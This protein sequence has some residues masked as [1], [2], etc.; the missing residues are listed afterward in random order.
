MRSSV[1]FQIVLSIISLS[2]NFSIDAQVFGNRQDLGLIQ[3]NPITEAS[4]I[5]VSRKNSDV[6][7]TH[8]DSGDLNRIFAF[9][10]QGDHLGVFNIAGV[11]NRDWEDIAVGPGPINGKQYI[12]VG[13]IG[14]NN[15]AYNLKYIYRILEPDVSSTQSSIDT[16]LLNVEKITFQ[17]PDGRRDAE[18]LMVDPLTKDIYVVSKRGQR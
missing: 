14:D 9:N 13:E 3:Y 7:W 5:A 4:G 12:Y 16:T 10:R 8:N 11:I 18:T 17:Y 6:L 2:F 1:L 15:A